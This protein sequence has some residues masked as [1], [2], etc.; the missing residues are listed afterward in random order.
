MIQVRPRPLRA[1][2]TLTDVMTPD[3]VAVDRLAT[4]D[5]AIALLDRYGFRHLPVVDCRRLV[6][7]V[8][9]HDL[10]LA[11]ALLP[12]RE[13]LRDSAGRRVPGACRVNE[14]L[15]APV[16]AL[17][18]A[19][20]PAR[21]ARDMVERSIG[22]I[23]IVERGELVGIVTETDLLR[24]FVERCSHGLGDALAADRLRPLACV[25]LEATLDEALDA[26]DHTIGHV[27]VLCEGRL[28]GIA[29]ERDLWTGLAGAA[30]R[31][32]RAQSEGRLEVREPRVQ[33]VMTLDVV[34]VGPR[35]SL[36]ACAVRMLGGGISALPVVERRS[37]LGVVTQ[38]G[39]LEQLA[40]TLPVD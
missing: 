26:V 6:G 5:Q 16:H 4:L 12:A 28:I 22:A 1:V 39:V 35:T 40:A 32:A 23:P 36:S 24:L 20:S 38:R 25:D 37:P 11:T 33:D 21:A 9:D 17:T 8:S 31:D 10:R 15:R 29:S 3:P 27:G 18:P 30:I 13:R 34:T 2:A 19:A 14:I 7:I